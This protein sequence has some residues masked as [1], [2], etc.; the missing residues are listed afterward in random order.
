V[1]SQPENQRF[2]DEQG[3]LGGALELGA[4][5]AV[6]KGFSAA[7]NASYKSAGWMIGNPYLEDK[8]NFRIGIRYD[9][10]ER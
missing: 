7:V 9:L 3:K 8:F 4:K 6:G 2:Y 1:W 10:S 5:Y